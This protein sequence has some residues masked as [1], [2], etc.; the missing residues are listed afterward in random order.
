ML[1]VFLTGWAVI[2]SAGMVVVL[3]SLRQAHRADEVAGWHDVSQ[4]PGGAPEL[5]RRPQD[6]ART[7]GHVA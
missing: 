7:H 6:H 3:G 1:S 5:G 2:A 4:S